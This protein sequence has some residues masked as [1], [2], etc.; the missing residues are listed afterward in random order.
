MSVF[1]DLKSK[2]DE[3]RKG[4]EENAVYYC[5][6]QILDICR[7]NDNMSEIVLTDLDNAEMTVEKCER[8]IKKYADKNRKGN[9]AVVPPKVAEDIIRKFYGLPGTDDEPESAE[10]VSA[11]IDLTAYL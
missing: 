9:C 7:G 11:G 4:H 10:P 1:D 8:E 6:E 3:Q 5:G 2:I